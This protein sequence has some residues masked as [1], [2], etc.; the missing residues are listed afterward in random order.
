MLSEKNDR[1]PMDKDRY[2]QKI[3]KFSLPVIRQERNTFKSNEGTQLP[4]L[5]FS[6]CTDRVSLESEN[7]LQTKAQDFTTKGAQ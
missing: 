7:K 5:E 1:F 2:R 4:H 6:L 3:V